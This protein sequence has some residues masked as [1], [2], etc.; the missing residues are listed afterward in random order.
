[1][2]IY[3]CISL[4]DILRGPGRDASF[5]RTVAS[6]EN[7]ELCMAYKCSI[8]GHAQLCVLPWPEQHCPHTLT[9]VEHKI[10]DR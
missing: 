8:V 10:S 9:Q 6:R 7:I 4:I 3:C 2:F 5:D 1:M